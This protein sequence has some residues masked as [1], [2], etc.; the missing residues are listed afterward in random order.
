MSQQLNFFASARDSERLRDYFEQNEL[1]ELRWTGTSHGKEMTFLLPKRS[2]QS[3]KALLQGVGHAVPGAT[4]FEWAEYTPCEIQG[5]NRIGV[6]RIYWGHSVAAPAWLKAIFQWLKENSR[7]LPQDARFRVMSDAE[8]VAVQ[9]I[10]WA[11]VV[12]PNG[13]RS[14]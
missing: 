1:T 10:A 13:L 7:Q 11:G 3:A 9:F 6:G 4:D 8:R 5:E 14:E 2:L 12:I